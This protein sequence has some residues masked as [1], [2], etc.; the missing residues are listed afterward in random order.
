MSA[1]KAK[2]RPPFLAALDDAPMVFDY[3]RVSSH[4]QADNGL[5]LP[6]QATDTR[7]YRQDKP[8]WIHG[9]DFQDILSGRKDA[10]PGY[11]RLLEAVRAAALAGRRVIVVVAALDR[12]GRNALERIRAYEELEKLGAEIHSSRDGGRVPEFIY[13]ILAAW[14]QEESRMIGARVKRIHAGIVEAGWHPPGKAAWGYR[15]EPRSEEQRRQG[16]P[17]SVLVPH[18]VEAPY[19]REMWRRIGDG[20]SLRSVAKWAAALPP[21]ARGE[22]NLGFTTVWQLCRT[23]VYIGRFGAHG[24]VTSYDED[25]LSRAAGRWEPLIKDEVWERAYGQLRLSARMPKQASGEYLLTGTLWCPC[26]ERMSGNTFTSKRSRGGEVKLYPQWNYICGARSRGAWTPERACTYRTPCR[27]IDEAVL[28]TL[29]EILEAVDQPALRAEAEAALEAAERRREDTDDAAR[30]AAVVGEVR[31]A[32]KNLTSAAVKL[33]S[34]ELDALGYELARAHLA[35]VIEAGRAEEARLRAGQPVQAPTYAAIVRSV[36]GW[37]EMLRS[38]LPTA[39]KRLIVGALLARVEPV[40]IGHG[41]YEVRG[42]EWTELGQAV[43]DVAL[44]V[45]RSANLGSIDRLGVTM[46]SMEPNKYHRLVS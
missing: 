11:Q 19:V 27:Q 40:R 2:T 36:S 28:E 44:A 41:Q 5:S 23:P 34:G 38:G 16:A 14:A 43:F 21:V 12:L 33:A 26:G 13:N 37:A 29:I 9:G 42:L 1:A 20:E 31:T 22:R 6:A 46:R 24:S 15:W 30:L 45:A 18:E 3:S 4:E 8:T 35:G 32:E 7:R 10:R 17:M 39:R 25:I